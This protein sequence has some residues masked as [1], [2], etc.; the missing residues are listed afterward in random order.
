MPGPTTQPTDAAGDG[1]P[2]TLGR[3]RAL[4]VLLGAAGA[5]TVAACGSAST[6]AG[7]STGTSTTTAGST[8]ATGST[9][10]CTEIPE[11]TAGPFPGDGSNGPNVLNQDGV[12]RS[13]IRSSFGGATGTADGVPLTIELAVV[14]AGTC[15]PLAGAAVYAWHC[16]RDGNYSLYADGLED[17]NYLRGVQVT[18]ADGAVRFTSIFPACYSG[19][20]PHVHFEVY[21]SLAEAQAGGTPVATS[22][23]AF[24]P[25]VC[26]QV[27]AT[28][29]YGTSVRALAQVSLSSDN[30]FG[31]DGAAHQL[32]TMAG[33]P[34][35]GFTASLTAAV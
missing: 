35:S 26:E 24:P 33:D 31:D 25:D 9:A 7:G 27:Y 12:V 16:D 23:L 2:G 1:P 5:V 4:A 13:D 28:D 22:Q 15:L 6:R 17:T 20:W 21:P 30:V 11:E 10:E 32:A 34:A 18:D 14:D 3:R 8:T 19:R 29:G